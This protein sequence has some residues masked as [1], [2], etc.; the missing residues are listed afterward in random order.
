MEQLCRHVRD[1]LSRIEKDEA[2]ER[3]IPIEV[4]VMDALWPSSG[5]SRGWRAREID[6][7]RREGHD[8][9]RPVGRATLS[10]RNIAAECTRKVTNMFACR[11]S[12]QHAVDTRRISTYLRCDG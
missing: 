1:A 7:A 3:I 4:V 8:A 5:R 6:G 12:G 2:A 10:L 9:S 11:D